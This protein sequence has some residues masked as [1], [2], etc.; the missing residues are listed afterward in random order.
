MNFYVYK[1]A[2][3]LIT[4]YSMGESILNNEPGA[5]DKYISFLS[6]GGR[7]FPID[8]LKEAGVDLEKDSPYNNAF[9]ALSKL[10]S[11]FEKIAL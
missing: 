3:G 7:N 1:Y 4:A 5:I 8:T 2:T 9:S 6:S 11:E 10:I